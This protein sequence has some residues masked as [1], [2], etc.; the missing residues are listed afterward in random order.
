MVTNMNAYGLLWTF[1]SPRT[2]C[3][4]PPPT[5]VLLKLNMGA[6][7][8]EWFHIKLKLKGPSAYRIGRPSKVG[9]VEHNHDHDASNNEHDR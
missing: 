7:S 3:P 2:L 1:I 5:F 8:Q 9:T 6:P 4:D